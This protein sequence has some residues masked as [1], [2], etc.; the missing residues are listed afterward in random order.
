MQFLTS[1]PPVTRG[2]KR[3]NKR[4][5]VWPNR[6]EEYPLLLTAWFRRA[7]ELSVHYCFQHRQQLGP[8]QS[9]INPV[10]KSLPP[11]ILFKTN[12][13]KV[14]NMVSSE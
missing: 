9:Q 3:T 11:H 8:I 10:Y 6:M 5:F 1:H 13:A 7:R 12:P 14:E 4:F 2:L